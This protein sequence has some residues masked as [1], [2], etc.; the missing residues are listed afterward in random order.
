MLILCCFRVIMQLR[1]AGA[2]QGEFALDDLPDAVGNGD[3][4]SDGDVR[5]AP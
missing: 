3:G 2:H 1:E 4:G 5:A